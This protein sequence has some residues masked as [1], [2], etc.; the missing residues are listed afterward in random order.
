MGTVYPFKHELFGTLCAIS[1][2]G[3]P[4]FLAS[5]ACGVLGISNMAE[6]LSKL[7]AD[8]HKTAAI[9]VGDG[10]HV[11]CDIVS[12]FG[13]WHLA[14]DVGT[15]KSVELQ[16]W[17]AKE[18]IP[19]FY[20]KQADSSCTELQSDKLVLTALKVIS[21]IVD[22]L[23]GQIA[24]MMPK[25]TFA[26]A[27]VASEGAVLIGD[28]AKLLKQNGVDMDQGKLLAWMR[29]NG[30]L[31]KDGPAMNTPTPMAANL[32]LF[33]VKEHA[34]PNPNGTVSLTRTT[35]VT[36]NGQVY[37]VNKFLGKETVSEPA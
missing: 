29:D 11:E 28:L 9:S 25:V 14:E 21:S 27:V 30:Y 8:E 26:D 18:V 31:V 12:D 34:T 33:T 32:K 37:F 24:Q 16:N 10:E 7:D 13:L 3:D 1:I 2:D 4:W 22:V 19:T 15:S 23:M 36:G 20:K 17:L 6:A 5:E 35:M